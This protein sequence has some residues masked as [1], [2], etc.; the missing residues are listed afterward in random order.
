VA[1]VLPQPADEAGAVALEGGGLAAT[2]GLAKEVVVA[3]AGDG[4]MRV[5]VRV[6]VHLTRTRRGFFPCPAGKLFS[7]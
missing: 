6:H 1:E 5:G 3:R 2:V 7:R 4:H